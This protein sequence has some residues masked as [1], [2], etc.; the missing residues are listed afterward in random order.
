M[1][2][3]LLNLC[4]KIG[5]F[6][7]DEKKRIFYG[8]YGQAIL[9]EIKNLCLKSILNQNENVYLM[10][11]LNSRLD[12]DYFIETSLVSQFSSNN[13]NNKKKTFSLVNLN[14]QTDRNA[15][16]DDPSSMVIP[17]KN[18]KHDLNFYNF[19]MENYN[20]NDKLLLSWIRKRK[21]FWARLFS[22]PENIEMKISS[23]DKNVKFVYKSPN[24]GVEKS[25]E[26][27]SC[28]NY[29]QFINGAIKNDVLV[30]KMSRRFERLTFIQ[31]NSEFIFEN[32][33]DDS[34]RERVLS[35]K[36]VFH[37]DLRVCP[38]K[39]CI[40]VKP[41]ANDV[42][43]DLLNFFLQSNINVFR[44]EFNDDSELDGLFD[45]FDELGIPFII[46]LPDS[47]NKDGICYLRNRETTIQEHLHFTHL[48]DQ[49]KFLLNSIDQ[50]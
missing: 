15:F 19:S 32:L 46:V 34:I 41:N 48:V 24:G 11:D 23:D 37:L 21:S 31:T 30:S 36:T 38:Y 9:L 6:K 3:N 22:M 33:L 14:N 29:D 35:K 47:I 40:L 45:R 28:F 50:D 18:F 26:S 16:N 1:S 8:P 13:D 7:L 2:K 42:S 4:K 10:D 20:Q 39:A 44:H 43:S 49:F 25:L 5:L 17:S 12:I 27:I